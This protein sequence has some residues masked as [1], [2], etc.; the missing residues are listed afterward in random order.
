M[1]DGPIIR[2]QPEFPDLAEFIRLPGGLWIDPRR[3]AYVRPG[4]DKITRVGSCIGF[5]GGEVFIL[6]DDEE[7]W[8]RDCDRVAHSLGLVTN[9]QARALGA[10]DPD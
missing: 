6:T 4:R 5:G 8:E 9:S 2:V 1:R 10:I 3:V 7:N